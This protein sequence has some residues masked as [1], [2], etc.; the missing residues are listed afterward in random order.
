MRSCVCP[1][2]WL[3][4]KSHSLC[5]GARLAATISTRWVTDLANTLEAAE[6]GLASAEHAG[7]GT[8]GAHDLEPALWRIDSAVD[9][10]LKILALT[11][12]SKSLR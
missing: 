12:A 3:R 10:L 9:R 1:M 5:S 4:H 11:L 2:G 8:T 7:L 6:L